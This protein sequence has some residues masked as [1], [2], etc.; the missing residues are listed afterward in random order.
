MPRKLN[1]FLYATMLVYPNGMCRYKLIDSAQHPCRFSLRAWRPRFFSEPLNGQHYHTI[2]SRTTD[3]CA[4]SP[5]WLARLRPR[6][7]LTTLNGEHYPTIGSRATDRCAASPAWLARP[8]EATSLSDGRTLIQLI[9]S[10]LSSV[11]KRPFRPQ[12]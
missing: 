4:A 2:S 12:Q 11:C 3:S 1:V 8:S 6:L 7:F 9:F 10:C 5:A